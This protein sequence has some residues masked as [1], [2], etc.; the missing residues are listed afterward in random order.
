L[1]VTLRLAAA[2]R[3]L[4]LAAITVNGC[5]LIHVICSLG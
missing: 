4:K 5:R 2:T 1:R 3:R